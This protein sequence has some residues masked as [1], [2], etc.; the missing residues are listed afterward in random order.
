M[1]G[2]IKG[3]GG[4]IN[5]YSEKGHGTTFRLYL[6]V[7]DAETVEEPAVLQEIRRGHE[8][9]LIV[10]DEAIILDVTANLLESMGYKVFRAQTDLTPLRSIVGR[11]IISIWSFWI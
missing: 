2:I 3:H 8:T 6:P 10:D 1:Y 9:I 7:S 5:V 11:A 4:I